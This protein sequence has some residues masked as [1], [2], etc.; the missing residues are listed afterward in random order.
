MLCRTF[1]H[2]FLSRPIQEIDATEIESVRDSSM[3]DNPILELVLEIVDSDSF[4][5]RGAE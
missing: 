2:L 5:R 3:S 1:I 4:R